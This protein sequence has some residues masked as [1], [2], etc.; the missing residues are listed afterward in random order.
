[1]QIFIDTADTKE[2]KKFS[3]I[4]IID[5]VTTNPAL[6]AKSGGEFKET[7]LKIV[8]IIDGPISVEVIRTDAK[9]MIEEGLVLSSIHPN[10]VVKIPATWEGIEAVK[11]L[12]KKGV[13]TNLTIVYKTNQAILAA[14]AGATYVSP[15]VGRLDVTSTSGIDLIKEIV[16]VYRI[17][18]FKTKVLAASMRNEIYVKMAALAGADAVTIPPNVLDQMM[19][20]ELT[21]LGLKGFLEDWHR[22]FPQHSSLKEILKFQ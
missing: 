5:G 11:E 8:K 2:I 20:S 12:S 19:K 18:G 21:Q 1:M 14:K 15:F 7:I 13:K 3:K 22:A 4:G 10:I 17:Y 9:G 6:I 16:E